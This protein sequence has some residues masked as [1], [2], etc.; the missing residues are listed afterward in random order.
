MATHILNSLSWEQD[1]GGHAGL[2]VMPP[3]GEKP[4]ELDPMETELSLGRDRRATIA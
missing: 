1:N 2:T 4:G 3:L